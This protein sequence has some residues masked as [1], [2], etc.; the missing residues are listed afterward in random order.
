MFE[1]VKVLYKQNFEDI[2]EDI[3]NYIHENSEQNARKFAQEVKNK[4]QWIIENPTAGNIETQIYSKQNWYRF[5]IVMKSWKIVYK[6]TNTSLVFLGIIHT[7]RNSKQI[8]KLRTN[9]YK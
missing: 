6:K 4:L 2:F 5:K 8:E 3:Y 1:K 9:N 7:K